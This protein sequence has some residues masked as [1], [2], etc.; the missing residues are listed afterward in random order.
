MDRVPPARLSPELREETNDDLKRRR[1]T[2]LSLAGAFIGAWPAHAR[3]ASSAICPTCCRARSSMPRRS[4]IKRGC[5]TNRS[6]PM[7]F[8]SPVSA[9]QGEACDEQGLAGRAA[10]QGNY[11]FRST[12]MRTRTISKRPKAGKE[13]TADPQTQDGHRASR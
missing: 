8:L 9:R 3:S 10:V 5:S 13:A 7:I 6:G 1:A 12:R 11:P 4:N 2:G